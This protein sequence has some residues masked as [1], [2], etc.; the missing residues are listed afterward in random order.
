MCCGY[1]KVLFIWYYIFYGVVIFLIP[2]WNRAQVFIKYRMNSI[3]GKNYDKVL[4][5]VVDNVFF[6][7]YD[8]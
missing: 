6:A 8:G 4:E 2:L 3:Q 1:L 7:F 5:H